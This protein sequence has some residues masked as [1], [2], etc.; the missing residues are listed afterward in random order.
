MKS[1]AD[2]RLTFEKWAG[3]FI[4]KENLADAGFYY[5]D[6]S[7]VVCC[8]FCVAQMGL[9]QEG[10]DAFKEHLLWSPNSSSL[11]IYLSGTFLSVLP[12][13]LPHRPS[14]LPK[15]VTCMVTIWNIDPIDIPND[16]SILACLSSF[17][18]CAAF[19]APSLI[20]NVLF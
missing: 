7:E 2:R 13:S 18:K 16:V 17:S 15:A 1:E 19:I 3:A 10:G 8:A 11:D 14:S 20:S 9:W 5:T 12:T 6:H 4:D